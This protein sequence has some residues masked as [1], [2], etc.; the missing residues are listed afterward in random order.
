V[1]SVKWTSERRQTALNAESQC[2]P[3]RFLFV[4]QL[5]NALRV[6]ETPA[7]LSSTHKNLLRS[8]G[9]P[10]APKFVATKALV[11]LV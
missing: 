10:R 4:K 11:L 9:V 2:F 5:R 1:T 8:N 3:L 6:V 7:L